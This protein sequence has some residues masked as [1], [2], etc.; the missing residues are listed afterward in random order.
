[1]TDIPINVAVDRVP[2]LNRP[3]FHCPGCGA[4]AHQWWVDL[5][6]VNEAENEFAGLE[7]YSTLQGSRPEPPEQP[8]D[9]A[10]L[11]AA[12]P[13][14]QMPIY[15]ARWRA[16]QCASCEQWS[17]WFD[18]KMVHPARPAGAPPH[19]DMP[20]GVRDLYREAAAVAAVSRRAG[21]ALARATVERLVKEL[22]PDAPRRARLDQRI[23]RLRDRVS[24]PLAQL[25]DVVRF[26]GNGALHVDEQPD[27]LVIITMD[28]TTGPALV[29]MMLQVANDLVDELITRP[30]T[31]SGY[32]D[33]LPDGVKAALQT[34]G[35]TAPSK[36]LTTKDDCR[37]SSSER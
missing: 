4:F 27:E 6:Y 16:A 14:S 26:V 36:A 29:E 30:K 9:Q 18:D 23:G 22:D 8:P 11:W 15:V 3:S 31:T 20:V 37:S 33:K 13:V 7:R 5:G 21:A 32:W 19:Q 12:R 10:D 24:T 2:S 25:L 1:M 28:D 34:N 35:V 17:I